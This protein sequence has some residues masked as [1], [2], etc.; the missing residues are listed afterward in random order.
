MSSTASTTTNAGLVVAAVTRTDGGSVDVFGKI[1][2]KVGSLCVGLLLGNSRRSRKFS[3]IWAVILFC[4]WISRSSSWWCVV[5]VVPPV[6]WMGKMQNVSQCHFGV[7]IF[8]W[9]FFFLF[10]CL[11]ISMWLYFFFFRLNWN[12]CNIL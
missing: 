6:W 3:S 10:C 4:R 1:S 12:W 11:W 5:P 2:S 9:W 7:F 8:F